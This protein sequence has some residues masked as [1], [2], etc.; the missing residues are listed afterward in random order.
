M[1]NH[2]IQAALGAV[3]NRWRGSSDPKTF[4]LNYLFRSKTPKQFIMAFYYGYLIYLAYGLTNSI[5]SFVWFSVWIAVGWGLA[6]AMGNGGFIEDHQERAKKWYYR[7]W[8]HFFGVHD[9]SWTYEQRVFRD[10]IFMTVRGLVITAGPGLCTCNPVIAVS[11]AMMGPLYWLGWHIG[12]KI[13]RDPIETCE[14]LFGAFLF[15][16]L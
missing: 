1:T 13:K 12:K 7:W 9:K 15:G 6:F 5:I 11:G 14:L 4:W 10:Y 8:I 2:L 16:I 3:L